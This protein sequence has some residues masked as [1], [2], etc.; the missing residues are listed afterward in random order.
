MAEVFLA[1][2]F[3]VGGFQKYVAIKKILPHIGEDESFVIMFIDEAKIVSKLQHANICQVYEFG[4]INND[5]YQV[6]E[7][8]SGL[9][10]KY[11]ARSLWKKN[12]QVPINI[13]LHMISE[14]CNGLDYAHSLKDRKGKPLNIIHRDVTPANILISFEGAV[15]LIDFGIAKAAQRATKTQAGIVKGKFGYMTPEQLEG[16]ELDNR[17]D[18][19]SLGIGLWELLAGRLLFNES[20]DMDNLRKIVNG[21]YPDIRDVRPGI[22]DALAEVVMK[23]LAHD[24]EDRYS[25]A[26]E[27]GSAIKKVSFKMGSMGST[28]KVQKFISEHFKEDERKNFELIKKF[29]SIDEKDFSSFPSVYDESEKEEEIEELDAD[30]LMII[31]DDDVEELDSDDLIMESSN[32]TE[33]FATSQPVLYDDDNTGSGEGRTVSVNTGAHSLNSDHSASRKLE[34]SGSMDNRDYVEEN[35]S[36][37]DDTSSKVLFN[38]GDVIK[39]SNADLDYDAYSGYQDS[40]EYSSGYYEQGNSGYYEPGNSGY[41]ESGNS[42]YY[43]QGNS[44]YYEPDNSGYYEPIDKSQENQN[45]HSQEGDYYQQN[46][47]YP[48]GYYGEDG[49]WYP[50]DNTNYPQGYYGEDGNWYPYDYSQYQNDDR[51]QYKGETQNSATGEDS[52]YDNYYSQSGE[53]YPQG[54]YGEDGN[55]YP[56]DNTNYPQ[57]YY[58][59]DGN[60][61]PY[62]YNDYNPDDSDGNC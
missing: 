33:I 31:D 42:G 56:Y 57:G 19:F 47:N 5:F 59:E 18:I 60:W 35:S 55:W 30:D 46:A 32:K 49:N 22:D 7:Y 8:I 41:Y 16:K 9:S 43:E 36:A 51:V 17:S 37:P 54:Y 6:M 4:K 39:D 48:Q 25:T 20:N 3:G 29:T 24:R 28:S 13:A 40:G 21:D 34:L 44:G 27:F 45:T 11:I 14:V 62:D 15:K 26:D 61:Y 23:A 1:K 12:K 50:Y 53:Y 2:R 58:G 10:I 52:Q 38:E